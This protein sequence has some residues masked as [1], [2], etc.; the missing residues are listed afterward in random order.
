MNTSKQL[1]FAAVALC[2][3]FSLASCSP[4]R[5]R[6]Y[7]NYDRNRIEDNLFGDT[8]TEC[9]T[10]PM[11]GYYR[12]GKCSTGPWDRGTHTV[13]AVM[14][15]EF[16]Q[17]SKSQGNDL[18]TPHPEFDFPGLKA[19]DRW[20]LCATRW[21]QAH[22]AGVAPKVHMRS[23]HYQTLEVVDIKVLKAHAADLQ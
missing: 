7:Y 20:C 6:N 4:P 15:D 18:I 8:L 3:L 22:Q 11:T 9:S 16:L 10:D 5:R 2:A 13:C 1:F 14:T 21:L 19:G 12:N 23:T 17:Y